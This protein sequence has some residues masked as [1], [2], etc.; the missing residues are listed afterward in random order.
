MEEKRKR[1]RRREITG[2]EKEEWK[3]E[4]EIMKMWS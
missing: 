3:V 4:R 2:I 1:K